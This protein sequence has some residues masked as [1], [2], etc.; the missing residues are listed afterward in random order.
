MSDK[1]VRIGGASGAW[2]DSPM[3]I[4]QLLGADVQY[5]M[6]D[7]LAEVTMSLLARARMKDPEAGYPPDVIDYLKPSLPEIAR[8]GIKV[9][10]NGGG[11]NPAACKR[12][13]EAALAELGLSLRVAMV[14]GDDVMPLTN[15]L[16][17]GGLKEAVSGEPLP[18]RL[19]TANA[20]LGALP[21]KAAFD[22]GADIVIT[23]RCVDSALALGILMHE[24]GWGAGDY[25]LLGAG[26][27]VGHILECGAQATGGNFTDWQTVPGWH[28][29]G[30]PVAECRSDGTFVVC[31]P[32]GTG[33]M[34]TPAVVSEQCL[35]EIGDPA[36]YFLPDVV[37][38][39]SNVHLTQAG[40]DRVRVEGARGRAP[41]SQYKV[42]ATYQDGYRAV[43]TV[44]IVGPDAADKAEKTADA[45]IERARMLFKRRG[46]PDFSDT[47]V[48][49][50]GAEASYGT[51]APGRGSR[52]VLLRVAVAHPN[53]DALDI[54]A[55]ELG[56][57]P[58]SCAPGTTGI[59][60]GR[61][62]P[63]PVVR[64]FTFFIDKAALPRPTVRLGDATPFD[65]EIPVEGGYVAPQPNS[66]VAVDGIPD[67][68]TVALPLVRLAY[69]RSGDK[70]NSAN[71]A[72]IAREPRFL[73]LL[74]RE[75]TPERVVAQ[76]GH[77]VEG[78]ARRFE[79]PGL[80]ALNFVI[81]RALGGGGMASPRIDPQGKAYGQ[82]TLEMIIPVPEAWV[83]ARTQE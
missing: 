44:S 17:V 15:A 77:L 70:A 45:L 34:V 31:K 74:R 22:A 4:P 37:A 64:L 11:V 36:A 42:S 14:E 24:F 9:A 72:I 40:P 65:I 32:D 33:G 35:Y 67:G 56:A 21:I 55:R 76:L 69:G 30:Y 25:D 62:H 68:P 8:R 18:A 81:E 2:G 54:F 29:I 20:Y 57:V 43:A 82:M 53:R 60:S 46:L 3:A 61:P 52:E 71:V 38:D 27:L 83:A 79:A 39:F 10:T 63:T 5:L 49:T 50:L 41:T 66:E 1:I 16:R 19:L 58:L 75:V 28:N 48:E 47:H 80:H 23:G 7:Y 73:P 26:S 78:P 12:A 59:Y 51:N 6:M 13:L